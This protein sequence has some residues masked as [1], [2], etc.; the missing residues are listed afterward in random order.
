MALRTCGCGRTLPDPGPSGGRPRS[1][2]EVCSPPR[3]RDLNRARSRREQPAS[4]V[5]QAAEVPQCGPVEA[6][7]L[8]QLAAAGREGTPAGAVAL[9]LARQLDSG[10]CAGSQSAAVAD[11]LLKAIDVAMAGVQPE[12]DWVDELASRRDRKAAGA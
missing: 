4:P 2:C 9:H 3:V 6:A 10:T 7:T 1:K 5:V 12:A 11:K 8:A